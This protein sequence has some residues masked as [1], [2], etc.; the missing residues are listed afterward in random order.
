MAEHG[1]QWAVPMSMRGGGEG[2]SQRLSK[3][4]SGVSALPVVRIEIGIEPLAA[5][6]VDEEGERS[7]TTFLGATGG[8]AWI[9]LLV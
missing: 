7:Y 9:T 5:D 8:G 1:R 6:D 2:G 4:K 3:R